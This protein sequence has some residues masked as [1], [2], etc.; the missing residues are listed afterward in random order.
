MEIVCPMKSFRIALYPGDGIGV[1]VLDEAVRV[2]N[3]VQQALG[4]FELQ[5]TR[6]D[7]GCA[8]CAKHGVVAPAEY[9]DILRPFDA[10]F[11]GAIGDPRYMPDH[12]SLVPLVQIRQRF[13]QYAC[14]RPAKLFPN[15]PS[16]LAR[17]GSID[18]VVVRENSE[19]EYSVC[20]GRVKIGRPEEV[21]IQTSVHT[22]S[23]IQRILRY[24]FELARSRRRRLTMVT[25]SNAL[26]F[27]M[28]LWDEVLEDVRTEFPDIE[29]D[30]QHADAAAM[31]FVRRPDAFDVVVASNLFGDIL[32]DLAGVITGGIGLAPSA[33]IN[34]ERTF[35]SMFEPVH[36]S[37]PD[38]AD[39]GIANPA[40]AI[41]SGAMMLE[42][43]GMREAAILIHRA[44]EKAL[45]AGAATPDLGGSLTT[46]QMTERIIE[47]IEAAGA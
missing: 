4:G 30:R 23:G 3:R 34:P 42:W 9:L 36:G 15:V 31:N 27:G 8:Y 11:L 6:F 28:A 7:W 32:S 46:T 24:G 35:P 19:G 10:I 14:L 45:A 37:A 33:N 29:A 12:A 25:K 47:C 43:L 38:I 44:V 13:D 16:P 5:Y 26:K 1:E 18:M 39:K 41:L 21:A 40:A 22:R 17:P 20:G 2:L